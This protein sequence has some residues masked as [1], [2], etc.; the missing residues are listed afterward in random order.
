MPASI[1]KRIFIGHVKSVLCTVTKWTLRATLVAFIWLGVVPYFTVWI[2]RFYFWNTDTSNYLLSRFF[3]QPVVHN[4]T[5]TSTGSHTSREQEESVWKNIMY[6]CLTGWLISTVVT[7]VFIGGFLLREW[8]LQN[9]PA[10]LHEM[11]DQARVEEEVAVAEL[12]HEPEEV[13]PQEQQQQNAPTAR[14]G[15][16]NNAR[17]P[18]LHQ[19]PSDYENLEAM[20]LMDE[21]QASPPLH[22]RQD[23]AERD[24]FDLDQDSEDDDDG[25]FDESEEEDEPV[26]RERVR[27]ILDT[28]QREQQQ[29]QAN[30]PAVVDAH[31]IPDDGNVPEN[32]DGAGGPEDID[33]ILEIIG[34][35][36]SI[37]MLFQNS[38]LMTLLMSLC[39]GAGVW[40]PYT[41]GVAFITVSADIHHSIGIQPEHV[42][43][44]YVPGKVCSC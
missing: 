14:R 20:W 31:G 19:E 25:Y 28:I 7:S 11:D 16:T 22:L 30:D 29:Q 13:Q 37:Y 42:V 26:H 2:W 35:K 3:F 1:P 4:L 9:V 32:Q 23:R 12:L 33:G 17:R 18:P 24:P 15:R 38:G 43:Y 21:A 27:E 36:G 8:V 44:R 10:E 41:M 39:L 6:D 5:S 34:M 40:V